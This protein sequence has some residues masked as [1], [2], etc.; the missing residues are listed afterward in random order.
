MAAVGKPTASPSQ[1]KNGYDAIPIKSL[2][3]NGGEARPMAEAM[4]VAQTG[5]GRV[6]GVD[7]A[8]RMKGA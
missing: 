1:L 2:N 4:K 6:D 5:K 3:G 8:Y 7:P